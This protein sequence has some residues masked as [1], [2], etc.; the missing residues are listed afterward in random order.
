MACFNQYQAVN[1]SNNDTFP[2]G[3]IRGGATAIKC[4]NCVFTVSEGKLKLKNLNRKT[5]D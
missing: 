4:S 3:T 1:L 2:S 5:C